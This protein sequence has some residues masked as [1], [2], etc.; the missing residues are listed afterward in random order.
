M[1][2]GAPEK[3]VS[4]AAKSFFS[5]AATLREKHACGDVWIV[6]VIGGVEET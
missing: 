1:P 6:R 2:W 3:R 4:A 5:K